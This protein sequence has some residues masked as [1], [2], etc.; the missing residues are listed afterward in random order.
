MCRR[1]RG[2][3]DTLWAQL[4]Q[5]NGTASGWQEFTVPDPASRALTPAYPWQRQEPTE[6][7]NKNK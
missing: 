7:K 1:A 4:I 3:A 6:E 5:S 2:D